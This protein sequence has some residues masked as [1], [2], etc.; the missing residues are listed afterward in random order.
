MAL[1]PT[2]FLGNKQSPRTA[3]RSTQRPSTDSEEEEVLRS[4]A[5]YLFA[6]TTW[7]FLVVVY[8]LDK[9]PLLVWWPNLVILAALCTAW[10]LRRCIP[11]TFKAKGA[12][13]VFHTWRLASA[14]L[15]AVL[16]VAWVYAAIGMSPKAF[17]E[18][19]GTLL[20]VIEDAMLLWTG[21][22]LFQMIG[23]DTITLGIP[24]QSKNT[25]RGSP[26]KE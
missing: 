18:N 23:F 13:L 8:Y 11:G 10:A 5:P 16:I 17:F 7:V 3:E 15:L 2:F 1:W 4:I 21:A 25:G 12:G 14:A 26:P 9:N 24:H 19:A 22:V 20:W 6:A